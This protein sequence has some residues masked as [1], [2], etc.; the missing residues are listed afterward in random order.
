[1]AGASQADPYR[2]RRLAMVEVQLR[3]RGIRDERVL[4][5]MAQVPRHLFV[6]PEHHDDAYGDFPLP[7][8]EGQTISQPYVVAAMLEAL[9]LRPEDV[10]LEIGTGSGYQTALLAELAREVYSIERQPRLAMRAEEALLRLGYTN[11]HVRVGDG[12]LGWPEAAP[13]EAIIVAAAAPQVPP[14]L[15]DQLREGAR[16]IVPVGSTFAQELQLIRKQSGGTFVTHL[17]GCRFVPLIGREGFSG[18]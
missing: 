8:G 10:V 7:I 5:A 13:F 4:A 15:F 9:A 11:V 18:S 12:T 6:P 1:M 14:S 3:A 17:D 16:M 2:M